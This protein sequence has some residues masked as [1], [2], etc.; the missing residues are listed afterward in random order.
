VRLNATRRV[1]PGGRVRFRGRLLGKPIPRVGKLVDLQ[2]FDGGRWR[3]FAT[4]RTN[5]KGRYRAAYRFIRTSSPRTFRFR[6][7]ARK[8]ARYP[9]ALGTSKVVRV[10]VR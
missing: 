5:R 2:A 3:T 4:T 1:P 10:R 9:Y 6:A 7:R 8:E